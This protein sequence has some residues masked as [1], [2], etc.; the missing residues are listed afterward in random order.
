MQKTW[1]CEYFSESQARLH[2]FIDIIVVNINKSKSLSQFSSFSYHF[3]RGIHL[4]MKVGI[5]CKRGSQAVER[6]Q[7]KSAQGGKKKTA[8][9]SASLL[10]FQGGIRLLLLTTVL[11]LLMESKAISPNLRIFSKD[12]RI[13]EQLEVRALHFEHFLMIFR[14]SFGVID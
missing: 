2:V 14:Y 4:C 6:Q 5:C 11:H 9:F 13:Y 8:A 12:P 3:H 7:G 1:I 10:D